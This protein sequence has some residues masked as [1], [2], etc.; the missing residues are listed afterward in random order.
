[1]LTLMIYAVRQMQ[2][3]M[4]LPHTFAVINAEAQCACHIIIFAID[5]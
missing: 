1:M 5:I 2:E 3:R 4:L